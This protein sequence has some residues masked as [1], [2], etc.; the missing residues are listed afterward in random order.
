MLFCGLK[1]I[2]SLSDFSLIVPY[3]ILRC[4]VS[5]FGEQLKGPCHV[6]FDPWYLF[7]DNL[8]WT[9]DRWNKAFSHTVR[10]REEGNGNFHL[11]LNQRCH[12]LHWSFKKAKLIEFFH[13]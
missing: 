2:L 7:I 1:K 5:S 13:V 3:V 6:I 8:M 9:L 11:F 4:I 10:I 12:L